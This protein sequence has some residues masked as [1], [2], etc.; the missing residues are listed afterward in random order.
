[1]K[2][3]LKP[4]I[5]SDRYLLVTFVRRIQMSK[6]VDLEIDGPHELTSETFAN[7]KWPYLKT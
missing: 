3:Y 2:V 5:N 7:M 4:E 1:M 6:L